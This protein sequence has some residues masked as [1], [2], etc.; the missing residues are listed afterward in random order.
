MSFS[1][2]KRLALLLPLA[3]GSA[4]LAACSFQ[5]VYSGRLADSSQL[6]LRYGEPKNRL[7]QIIYNELSFRLGKST[8]PATALV[9]VAA[10][11]GTGEPFLSETDSPLT[12]RETAVTATLTMAPTNPGGQPTIITRTARAQSTRG[13][14]VLADEA[15]RIDAEERAARAVA[16]SLRLALLATLAQ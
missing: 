8:D 12:P 10:A 13:G 15:A 5:P 1:R 14:Q 11:T 16:E 2:L 6:A 7:E 3:F 9:T 4:A